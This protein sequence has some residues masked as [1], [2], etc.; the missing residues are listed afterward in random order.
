MAASAQKRRCTV[1]GE[2]LG[3]IINDVDDIMIEW[4]DYV[5]EMREQEL[6]II[7]EEKRL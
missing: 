2:S 6:I 7:I 5:I 1:S 4:H 3:A